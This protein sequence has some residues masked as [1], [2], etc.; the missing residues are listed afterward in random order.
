M[1]MRGPAWWARSYW[2]MLRWEVANLRVTLPLV[3]I[4]QVAL[5]GGA[6]VGLGFFYEQV[7]R[8]QA[9]YLATGGMLMSM[10]TVGL[11][12]V[13]SIIAQRRAEG[14]HDYLWVLPVPRMAMLLASLTVFVVVATP[15]AVIALALAQLRYDIELSVSPMLIPTI[16]LVLITTTSLGAAIGHLAKQPA[17]TSA[18]G[19]LFFIAMFLFSPI[20]YPAERLPGWLAALHEWLPFEHMANA[21]RGSLTADLGADVG[22][23]LLVLSGWAVL[24]WL[25]LF[26]VLARRA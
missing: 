25:L 12:F 14:A 13:P 8:L 7:P 22:R 26:Q 21:V 19:N 2:L 24:A 6:V 1:A 23:S 9:L 11:T 20:N 15:G 3:L 16:A 10:L 17:I 18:I 5:Y 4:I